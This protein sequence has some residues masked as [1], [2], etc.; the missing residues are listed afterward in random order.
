MVKSKDGQSKTYPTISNVHSCYLSW[1][2]PHPIFTFPTTIYQQNQ[3]ITQPTD[4]S[5]P[6]FLSKV[7]YHPLIHTYYKFSLFSIQLLLGFSSMAP[8]A[9]ML[10]LSTH[11]KSTPLTT[12]TTTPST[13][14]FGVWVKWVQE[15]NTIFKERYL[16]KASLSLP[17]NVGAE[18]S[19][20][21]KSFQESLEHSCWW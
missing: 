14:F 17:S 3:L 19:A 4:S 13:T 8:T 10:I 16:E 7:Y 21:E 6:V 1:S 15:N 11:I 18:D 2:W 20:L 5:L 9:A 12:S